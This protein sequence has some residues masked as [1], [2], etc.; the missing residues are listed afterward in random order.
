L[1]AEDLDDAWEN[2]KEAFDLNDAEEIFSKKD[3]INIVEQK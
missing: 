1:P 3:I 2:A